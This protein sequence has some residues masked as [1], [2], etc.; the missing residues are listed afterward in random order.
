MILV[1]YSDIK[2]TL[3][4]SHDYFNRMLNEPGF[5][6][7]ALPDLPTTTSKKTPADASLRNSMSL[8][9]S[10]CRGLE[11]ITVLMQPTATDTLKI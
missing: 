5:P 6:T 7:M 9:R 3:P 4:N 8:D 2:M 11:N 1:E 10:H